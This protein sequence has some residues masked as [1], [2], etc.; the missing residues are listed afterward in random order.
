MSDTR[1]GW[2]AFLK[3]LDTT[4]LSTETLPWEGCWALSV[5]SCLPP[6]RA[7]SQ[8]SDLLPLRCAEV[9]GLQRLSFQHF[10]EPDSAQ[11]GAVLQ[12][13]GLS[14][15]SL[16]FRALCLHRH[17]HYCWQ[18]GGQGDRSV[19]GLSHYTS[20]PMALCLELYC[21][22]SVPPQAT[23]P[24]IGHSHHAHPAASTHSP[25]GYLHV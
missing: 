8:H 21:I 1:E 12:D 14:L 3:V 10:S 13:T 22:A 20:C 19:Q 18:V 24:T 11:R 23:P 6:L 9:G 17:L 5:F 25:E 15:Q 4:V 2:H 7:T 16:G